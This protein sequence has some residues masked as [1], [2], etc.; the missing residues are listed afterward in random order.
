MKLTGSK[1]IFLAFTL[2]F[3]IFFIYRLL[4]PI[5]LQRNISMTIVKQKGVINSVDTPVITDFTANYYINTI[6]FRP[7]FILYHND[8]GDFAYD[9]NFFLFLNSTMHVKKEGLYTFIIAS[10][11]GFRLKLNGRLIGEFIS[12][13]SY[14]SN[15]YTIFLARGKYKMDLTYF[16]RFGPQ[17]LSAQYRFNE[18]P[19]YY[20][21]GE[22]SSFMSFSR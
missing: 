3:G 8:L 4:S 11:D 20:F 17:G 9:Q 18:S 19:I 2:L 10:D 14:N 6:N 1:L 22:D 7:G 5:V 12:D 21:F 15:L 13:R 16:Q